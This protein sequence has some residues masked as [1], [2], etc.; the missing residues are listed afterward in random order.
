MRLG[1]GEVAARRHGMALVLAAATLALPASGRAQVIGEAVSRFRAGPLDV[2]VRFGEDRLRQLDGQIR[3]V[4]TGALER[5]VALFGGPP[6]GSDGQPL[7]SLVVRVRSDPLGGGD[8]EPG[9]LHLLVG[10][11]P[12]FGFYDWRFTLLHEAFHLWSAES[13]RAAG[14][15][16]RWFDEGAAEF[17]AM[18][19]AARL[20]LVD[21][22][23]AI[24]N[25][26]TAAGFYASALDQ[27]RLSL[28][29]AGQ[30]N[31]RHHILVYHGGWA[32]VLLLDHA[33]RSRTSNARSM[34]HVLR[35]LYA[36]FDASRRR[37]TTLDVARGLRD[38]AGQD[39]TEFFARHVMGRLPLPLS[40]SVNL[41][42]LARG[43][44]ASRA[45]IAETPVDTILMHSLGIAGSRR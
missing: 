25:A 18:Q 10:R 40:G 27:H 13:F 15:S 37:Y 45:G 24:R 38:A 12:V 41:G 8:A 34:D 33:I 26:G 7:T 2:T 32:A 6:R 30:Q 29:E 44:Q 21:D 36:N 43:L 11:Q 1:R 31:G 5:Y 4:L 3:S 9:L 39:L 23:A 35:W 14:P 22:I 19:T 17:Y 16:E 28:V 42:E 20:D